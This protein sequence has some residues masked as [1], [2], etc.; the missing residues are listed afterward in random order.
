VVD[1]D[2]GEGVERAAKVAPVWIVDT[3]NNRHICE[4]L[5][6]SDPHTDYRETGAITCYKAPD[7]QNRLNSLLQIIPTLED[8]H[9]EVN[10]KQLV[11][12]N[13]FVLE[14][15]GLTLA[16]N[17]TSALREL[18]FTSFAQTSEGFNTSK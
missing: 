4:R 14:V 1:A 15:I 11:F 5:W 3:Q 17:V 10:D 16:D 8:H 9:G 7:P 13:G 2:Y 12:P 6:K 18:G